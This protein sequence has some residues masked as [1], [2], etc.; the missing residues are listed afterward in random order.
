M[1]FFFFVRQEFGDFENWMKIMEFDCKNI[2]AAIH[3]IHQAWSSSK[4]FVFTN[5]YV[6]SDYLLYN[7]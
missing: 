3:N 4:V 6:I 2:T 1:G 5:F 7:L